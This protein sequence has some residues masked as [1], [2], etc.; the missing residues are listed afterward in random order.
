MKSN[1]VDLTQY[2]AAKMSESNQIP[3]GGIVAGTIGTVLGVLIL[4]KLS[5]VS[6]EVKEA[7]RTTENSVSKQDLTTL[8]EAIKPNEPQPSQT[9]QAS[10]NE[11]VSQQ[12]DDLQTLDVDTDA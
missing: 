3:I 6:V 10:N 4:K 8:V 7:K 2:K 11:V 9:P 12:N 1:V 5:K